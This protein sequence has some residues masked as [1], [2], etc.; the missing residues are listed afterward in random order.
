MENSNELSAFERV[1]QWMST[2]ITLKLLGIGFILLLLLIPLSYIQ[3]LVRERQYRKH[4]VRNEIA[5]SWGFQQTVE[6]MVLSLPYEFERTTSQFDKNGKAVYQ[7]KTLRSTLQI[8][9]EHCLIKGQLDPEIK[10][11]GIF[12]VPVYQIGLEVSGNYKLP[13]NGIELPD[14]CTK[15]LWEEA[16]ATLFLSDLRRLKD[17]VTLRMGD[18]EVEFNSSA[19][20]DKGRLSARIDLS[21]LIE[22]KSPL[23]FKT[24]L[25]IAGSSSISFAPL[26]KTTEVHLESAWEHPKFMGQFLPE[27]NEDG[28]FVADWKVLHLNRSLAQSFISDSPDQN[29]DRFSFG[30]ELYTPADNYQQTER[31]AKYAL[32]LITLV[33]AL[34]F[35]VQVLRKIRIHPVQFILVGLSLIVF[36]TLLLSLSEHMGFGRSYVIAAAATCLLITGY[37]QASFRNR[38]F[39][40]SVLGVLGLVYA[41]IFSTLRM[42]DFSLLAGSIGIFIALGLVMFVT[43]NFD[44]YNLKS[45]ASA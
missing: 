39:S 34:F 26:A 2:S 17:Q 27:H 11:R 33:F 19:S 8:Y 16:E 30:V 4:E 23:E 10:K 9:P 36:Y 25:K 35:F 28:G 6:A 15:V 5:S 31:S 7:T 42:E 12:E 40:L 1:R 14:D 24:D 29:A 32:L 41:Y 21:T 3:D 37:I 22:N 20:Q 13:E 44:W 45:K 18:Q 38:L 43:R